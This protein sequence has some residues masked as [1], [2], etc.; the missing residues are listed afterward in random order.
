MNIE[1]TITQQIK[2]EALRLGFSACG[3]A[4][5]D[6]VDA[7]HNEYFLSWLSQGGNADMAYMANYQNQRLDPRI[8]HPGT[9]SIISLALNYYPLRKLPDNTYQFAYYAY[10]KDYHDVMKTRLRLLA[11]FITESS[12]A[13][14]RSNNP[15]Q[16]T[17]NSKQQTAIHTDT[18]PVLERYWA[19]KAGL[20]WIGRNHSLIIPGKGSFFVLGEI[21]T[22]LELD[23]DTP[24][25]SRCGS[26]HRCTD[27]CPCLSTPVF[28]AENCWSYQ[29]I[30]NKQP[31]EDFGCSPLAISRQQPI[32]GELVESTAN[33][34]QQTANNYIYGCDRC[35]LVCPHNQFATPTDIEE[36]QPS[37]MFLSMTKDDWNSL[38][39]DRYRTLFKGSAVKRAKYDK[40]M[41]TITSQPRG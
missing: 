6:G 24:M 2:A 20:G 21:F 31:I 18:A 1:Q 35:Q 13:H 17:A 41:S 4:R 15:E 16:Q 30:E 29:T 8:M 26:C 40:L 12:A 3:V 28:K 36:F 23:A 10:G 7:E 22:D 38:T 14:G 32:R 19:W 39:P 34:Q 9:K 37:S 27:I 5:A 33:S 11:S 25:Q